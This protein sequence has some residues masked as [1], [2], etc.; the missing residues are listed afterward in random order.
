MIRF[1]LLALA[2]TT[3]AALP[4]AAQ[5]SAQ[6]TGVVILDG[7]QRPLFRTFVAGEKRQS[8]ALGGDL[9]VGTVLPTKGV[10]YYAVPANYGAR[11]YRYTIVNNQIVLVNPSTREIVEIIN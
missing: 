2:V 9:R 1:A 4:A 3:A 7:N 8:V 10:T 6:A 11:G 5:N